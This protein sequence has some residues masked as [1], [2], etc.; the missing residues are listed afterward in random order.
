MHKDDTV[1]LPPGSM[2]VGL[3]WTCKRKVDLDASIICLDQFKNKL[4]LISHER[5]MG[6][7][8]T[9]RGDNPD[10]A[11]EGDDERIRIDF[12]NVP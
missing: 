1:Q 9:H 5:T 4:D 6:S 3:G 12:A 11:G 10:G 8:I 2:V 7:G